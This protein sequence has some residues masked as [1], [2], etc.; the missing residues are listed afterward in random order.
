MLQR[1]SWWLKA[2]S[3]SRPARRPS[4]SIATSSARLNCLRTQRRPPFW[5]HPATEG[6]CPRSSA[7]RVTST[8][9]MWR[10]KKRILAQG[11]VGDRDV[12]TACASKP[13][14]ISS[15]ISRW[16][17]L[18]RVGWT[19]RRRWADAR[20]ASG[21]SSASRRSRPSIRLSNWSSRAMAQE[22]PR[23]LA[24]RYGCAANR[25]TGAI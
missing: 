20:Q 6:R 17:S 12:A 25:R 13:S 21:L 22:Y 16:R 3:S 2:P 10:L 11:E 5:Q 4:A 19:S 18:V 7:S 1:A 23:G 24:A 8:P 15:A 9:Y 14:A